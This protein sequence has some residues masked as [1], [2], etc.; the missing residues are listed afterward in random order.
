MALSCMYY[1]ASERDFSPLLSNLL[2]RPSLEFLDLSY[3]IISEF[4]GASSLPKL[5]YL[6]LGKFIALLFMKPEVT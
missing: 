5:K 6:I 1:F 4:N 3:N 2:F